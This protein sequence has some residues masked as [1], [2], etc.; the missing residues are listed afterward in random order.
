MAELD[1]DE[2]EDLFTLLRRHNVTEFE[3]GDLAVTLGPGTPLGTGATEVSLKQA[4]EKGEESV[5]NPT[6]DQRG[7][8][9]HRSLWPSGRAPEFPG[10]ES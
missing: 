3:C 8:Y 2:L 6:S 7:V 5:R 10:K 1:L 4:I 9:G